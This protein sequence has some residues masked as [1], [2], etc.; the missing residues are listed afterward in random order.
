[1]KIRK[2]FLFGMAV[3]CGF[4]VQAHAQI[5][6]SDVGT[7]ANTEASYLESVEQYIQQ[8]EQ[9]AMQ[10]E[11]YAQQV[12]NALGIGNMLEE[13]G[14][15][16]L[17]RLAEVNQEIMETEN[18]L[19]ELDP[20]SSGFVSQAR[21]LLASSYD[22][23]SQSV[24]AS[25]Q[26]QRLYGGSGSSAGNGDPTSASYDRANR[27]TNQVMKNENA[28]ASVYDDTRSSNSLIQKQDLVLSDLGDDDMGAT[29]QLMAAQNSVLE[30]QN[31]QNI[32][33]QEVMANNQQE[34]RIRELEIE[35]R[36]AEDELTYLQRL[37][38]FTKSGY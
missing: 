34:E 27:D 38:D 1:M 15:S 10:G 22:L 25:A 19:N 3:F 11:Q 20:R 2:S 35:N 31:D 21:D 37:N 8:G 16:G 24:S 6:T 17:D 30:H 12:K 7:E 29:T 14:G 28:I 5:I 4:S 13:L 26:I 36:Q 33:L 18:V 23:P 9:Y 32:R